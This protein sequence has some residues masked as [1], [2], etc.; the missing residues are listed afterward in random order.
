MV[1]S[2]RNGPARSRELG[3]MNPVDTYLSQIQSIRSSGAG[4]NETSY[5]PALSG[6]LNEVGKSLKPKVQCV[7]QLKNL[8]AG[9]PDGGLFTA[10]QLKS[11]GREEAERLGQIP[12]RGAIEVKPPSEDAVVIAGSQQ[13]RKYLARYRQVLVTT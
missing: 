3:L 11:K 10:D 1:I 2:L 12:G 6:L 13:V 7:L 5:Y 4:V 9:N 8:G